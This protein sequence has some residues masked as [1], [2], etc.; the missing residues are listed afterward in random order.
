[1]K[2]ASLYDVFV[3]LGDDREA[4]N[5]AACI[6]PVASLSSGYNVLGSVCAE[7]R[8]GVVKPRARDARARAHGEMKVPLVTFAFNHSM[9]GRSSVLE[10]CCRTRMLR[11]PTLHRTG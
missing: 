4:L 8:M 1:M 6:Q 3:L 2:F 11:Y 9:A 7:R 5:L 10:S